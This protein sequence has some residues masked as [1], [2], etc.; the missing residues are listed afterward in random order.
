MADV[1]GGTFSDV[2]VAF[3]G[4]ADAAFRDA[5][6]EAALEGKAANAETI[7]AAVEHAAAGADMMED[8]YAGAA[9]RTHLAKVYAKRAL[10][11]LL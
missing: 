7:A 1:S 11:A 8:H 3:T 10:H 9:Y 5:G 6:V 4:A 2:R